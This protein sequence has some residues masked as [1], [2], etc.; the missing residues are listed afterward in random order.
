MNRRRL[1]V[2]AA[3]LAILAGAFSYHRTSW[4]YVE[5]PY[6]LGRLVAESTHIMVLKV[7]K[8]DKEKNL[9]IYRKVQ[10]LKGTWPGDVVKHNIGRGGFHPREWQ[11]IMEWAES[12]KTAV[13]FHNGQAS[14]TC[15]DKYWYQAYPGEW[16]AMSHAE[17]YLLRSYAGKPEKLAGLVTSI[18]AGQEVVVPCMLDGNK[19]AIQLRTAKI[20]RMKASLKLVEYNAQRDFVGWGGEDFRL[21]EGMP[22][23]SHFGAVGRFDPGAA[24]VAPVD[25]NGDGKMEVC[26]FGA[27]TSL[28]QLAGTTLEEIA[29]P[30]SGESRSACWADYNADGRP[31]LLLA[32]P[33]GPKLLT[34]TKTGFRDD[35]PGLPAEDYYNLSAAAWID[36]DSD[37][38]PDILLA[39]GFLGLRLY[40]NKGPAA[41]VAESGPPKLGPWHYAGPFDGPDDKRYDTVYPPEQEIDLAKQYPG[42]ANEPAVWKQKDF[43]DGQVNSLSLFNPENNTNVVAY[44]SREIDAPTAAEMAI[45]LGSDDSLKV[46]LNGEFLIGEN[47]GRGA[48]PDQNK[49]TL[50]LKPGKNRL[51]LKIGQGGGDFG[52]Y[53]AVVG[54]VKRTIPPLFEDASTL[55]GL[56]L[57]G[58][59]S[60]FKGD[61]L[62]VADV[63]GDGR[64]DFLY[65]AGTGLLAL[66]T[67][68]GFVEAKWSGL[69]FV[70]GKVGPVFGDFDGDK[71]VDLFVPQSGV[72]KLYKNIG[73]GKFTDVAAKSGAL[74]VSLGEATCAF[75]AIRG[76]NS[77]PD[78]YVGCLKGQNRV[79]KNQGNGAFTEMTSALGFDRRVF[80]TR[81][82][83]A[84]DLNG[85]GALDVVLSNE[86]Q[87]SAVLLGR[88]DGNG[89]AAGGK[90][91][92]AK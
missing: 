55:V 43:I 34:N 8:V 37:G 3:F 21:L 81:G 22:A 51:L 30:Y 31:D 69:S 88:L 39:N 46:W 10:D 91:A 85:D 11:N 62:A 77:R 74:A 9:I 56:G 68:K 32:T 71:Q 60:Q 86:G 2:L 23:Y 42:K 92:A 67:P 1:A 63:N 18:L 58:L 70:A 87:E 36:A 28:L 64:Q 15:I 57:E 50:K 75:W 79:F 54:E 76:K 66:N 38:H 4:G 83:A 52:F 49:T 61:H 33:E 25:V 19:E 82:I 53:F 29:L 84:V 48:A 78:L 14:E 73:G 59:G 47:V 13:F 80:N 90:T 17:P 40:K 89:P 24:G 20:Q 26:L 6:T 27:K 5:V 16:W 35:T 45:S 65:S 7:E 72:S 41:A 12:G 44:V